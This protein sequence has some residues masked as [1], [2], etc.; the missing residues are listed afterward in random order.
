MAGS[1]PRPTFPGRKVTVVG[2]GDPHQSGK[3][4]CNREAPALLMVA[5]FPSRSRPIQPWRMSRGR[6]LYECFVARAGF[7]E[8]SVNGNS[9][10]GAVSTVLNNPTWTGTV[11]PSYKGQLQNGVPVLSLTSTAL[12]GI[13]TPISLI[14]RP[15]PGEL[16]TAPA[17]F[18]QRL[19]SQATLRILI[20]D[21][22]TPTTVPGSLAACH[23]SDMMNL[24]TSRWRSY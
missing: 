10:Y 5:T 19:F 18:A 6:A 17:T 23:G 9:V 11:V 15:L 8:G 3:W 13:T 16:L 22:P 7:N 1:E 2:A 14:H 4:I 21:Y 24:D 12:G 20:D